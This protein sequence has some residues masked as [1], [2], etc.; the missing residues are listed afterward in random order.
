MKNLVQFRIFEYVMYRG[1]EYVEHIHVITEWYQARL[2]RLPELSLTCIYAAFIKCFLLR[3]SSVTV[4][5]CFP[6]LLCIDGK[7]FVFCHT[8]FS[9][10]NSTFAFVLFSCLKN[11]QIIDRFFHFLKPCFMEEIS[12]STLFGR[13]AF[14]W[15]FTSWMSLDVRLM[16]MTLCYCG[17]ALNLT[18]HSPRPHV[19]SCRLQKLSTSAELFWELM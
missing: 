19:A 12:L 1:N 7:L 10:S 4:T 5:M 16:K 2:P 8:A 11:V 13:P 6:G 17:L 15:H 18:F 3:K 14:W 9:K